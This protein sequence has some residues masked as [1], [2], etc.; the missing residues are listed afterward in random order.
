VLEHASD[1]ELESEQDRADAI[2]RI[3]WKIER[4]NRQL[5]AEVPAP[6]S[7]GLPMMRPPW[8]ARGDHLH[9]PSL[10]QPWQQ[11]LLFGLQSPP[12]ARQQY[13]WPSM[14]NAQLLPLQHS[15]SLTQPA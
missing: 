13:P 12:A 7:R 1:D 11:S 14:S 10:P 9:F 2:A 6:P 5:S 8:C 15:S 3:D 4:I